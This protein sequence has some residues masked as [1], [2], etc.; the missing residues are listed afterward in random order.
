[1]CKE[2]A[3]FQLT[4]LLGGRYGGMSCDQVD[5]FGLQQSGKN[6]WEE[7]DCSEWWEEIEDEVG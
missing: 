5:Q 7:V 4:A 1:M 3:D 2:T 6:S